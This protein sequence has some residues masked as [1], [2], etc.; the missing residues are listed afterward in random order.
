MMKNIFVFVFIA[1]STKLKIHFTGNCHFSKG[2][3]IVAPRDT[4]S[5][6]NIFQ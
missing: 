3:E 1:P 5:K 4:V 2:K 6:N